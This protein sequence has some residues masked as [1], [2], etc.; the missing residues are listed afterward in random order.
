MRARLSALA[1]FILAAPAGA[2]E[3]AGPYWERSDTYFDRRLYGYG[4]A[5]RRN[6]DRDD[7]DCCRGERGRRDRDERSRR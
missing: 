2:G 3:R 4:P 1:L 5:Y 7:R 6:D